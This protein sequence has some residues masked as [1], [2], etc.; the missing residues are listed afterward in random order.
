MAFLNNEGVQHLWDKVVDA[1]KGKANK[2][3]K[4]R[5]EDITGL[6]QSDW[7]QTDATQTDYIKNKPS[8]VTDDSGNIV[9]ADASGN[10]TLRSNGSG[11]ETANLSVENLTVNGVSIQNMVK[12][13]AEE[14]ILGGKW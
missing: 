1:L 10:T 6:P 12:A 14:I 11:F 9:I 4:H 8:V 3:H 5:V 13:C 7:N 2:K